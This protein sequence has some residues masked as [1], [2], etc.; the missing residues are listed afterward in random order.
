[1]QIIPTKIPKF[2]KAIFPNY[3]WDINTTNK[4]LYLTFDDGPT[5]QITDWVL[6]T[7][8]SYNAKATF[9]CIGNN[10]KQYPEIFQNIVSEQHSIGN[11]TYNHL[12]G[13]KHKTKDYINDVLKAQDIINLKLQNYHTK[14][15][16]YIKSQKSNSKKYDGNNLEL[17]T[18]NS[19]LFRPP[20]GKLKPQQAKII[21]K[22]GYKI[23]L[24]D[25]LSFD[26]DINTVEEECLKNVLSKSK[27]GSIIVFHDSIKAF[28]NLKYVLPKV[29]NYY[30][31]KEFEFKAIKL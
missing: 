15:N 9:F 20:Y 7:L 21:Q 22:E 29:L 30:S 5:P 10:I 8:K 2:V 1:M 12:R 23:V 17:K 25:V 31:N 27:K 28:K 14:H 13:W 18:L 19:K 3:V 24:W 6:K 4:E 16:Q 11:H 26:W